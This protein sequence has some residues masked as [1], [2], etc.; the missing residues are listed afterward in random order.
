VKTS[1]TKPS[2]RPGMRKEE[3]NRTEPLD[4]DMN[5]KH[6]FHQICIKGKALNSEQHN[7]TL[8]VLHRIAFHV[9]A[10]PGP[11]AEWEMQ[12]NQ[13]L[14][15]CFL[16]GPKKLMQTPPL[17]PLNARII[18]TSHPRNRTPPHHRSN[19]INN[20]AVLFRLLPILIIDHVTKCLKITTIDQPLQI[21]FVWA[22]LRHQAIASFRIWWA[23]RRALAA[24]FSALGG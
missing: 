23:S 9:R 10:V 14:K 13:N 16:H 15:L 2:T 22:E 5:T 8:L 6:P 11:E 21:L 4:H 3:T 17:H 19:T 18:K 20:N 1:T 7:F 12:K 24:L